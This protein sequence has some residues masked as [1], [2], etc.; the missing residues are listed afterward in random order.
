MPLHVI[1]V[2]IDNI[3]IFIYL[4]VG[5]VHNINTVKLI[6]DFLKSYL[7]LF[8]NVKIEIINW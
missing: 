1:F 8:K 6:S 4:E 3:F 5:H 7:F 2:K